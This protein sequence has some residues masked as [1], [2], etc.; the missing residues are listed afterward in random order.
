[1]GRYYEGRG[2]WIGLNDV[3]NEGSFTWSDKSAVTFANWRAGEPN[4]DHKLE[5]CVE[6]NQ[7]K[8]NDLSCGTELDFVCQTA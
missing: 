1:M 4:A 2:T 6:M 5:D 7:S 8:W 3:I